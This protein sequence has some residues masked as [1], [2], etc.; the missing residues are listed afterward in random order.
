MSDVKWIKLS[1]HMFDDEKIKLIESMP[2]ADTIL[3]IWI[4]LLSLAGR[5]NA[6]GY[7]YLSENIPFTDEMLSTLF[8]RPLNVV[9]L[10]IE[11][12]QSFGMI[13]ITEQNYICICNWEKHQNIKGLE[14]IREDTRLRVRKHREN[15]KLSVTKNV[16]LRN[17]TEKNKNRKELDKEVIPYVE[18][19]NY[20]NDMANT[21]Y[22]PTTRKTKDLIKA[23][24]NEGFNLDDFKTVIKNKTDEWQKTDMQ[25]YLRPE[26]LFGTKFESYLNQKEVTHAEH[27]EHDKYNFGF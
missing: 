18:I 17:A 16:T 23:R 10:A 3:I 7:I 5:T 9:R 19:V 14:K 25:K 1:T 12:L 24:C 22:K 6:T 27:Q 15:K 20:L 2:E 13:Q 4:K 21:K 26:T 8:N 11:T